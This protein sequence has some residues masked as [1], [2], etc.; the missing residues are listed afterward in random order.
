MN[1]NL[2]ELNLFDPACFDLNLAKLKSTYLIRCLKI[3]DIRNDFNGLNYF[4][5]SLSATLKL[6]YKNRLH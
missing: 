4:P 5:K 1:P 3:L 6:V 2:V